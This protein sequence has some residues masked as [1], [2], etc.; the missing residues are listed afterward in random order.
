MQN[1]SFQ[2]DVCKSS[3]TCR[4]MV[5]VTQIISGAGC[6]IFF[7]TQMYLLP[8]V[9]LLAS[10]PTHFKLQK[11]LNYQNVPLFKDMI[12]C[13]FF[14]TNHSY[15]FMHFRRIFSSTLSRFSRNHFS[16]LHSHCIFTGC[17]SCENTVK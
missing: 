1:G 12:A 16:R 15:S 6:N 5:P 10:P 11:L 9:F 13:I 7:I 14:L 8:H 4:K 2:Y 17:I 3:S